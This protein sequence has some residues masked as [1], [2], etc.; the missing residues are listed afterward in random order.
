[1]ARLVY[2]Y[3][4]VFLCVGGDIVLFT[5]FIFLEFLVSA[6]WYH[7]CEVAILNLYSLF[8]SILSC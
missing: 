1:M 7:L 4:V 6:L 3:Y 8:A 2:P 5:Y